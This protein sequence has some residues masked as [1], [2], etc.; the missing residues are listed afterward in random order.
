MGEEFARH[1]GLSQFVIDLS[2]PGVEIRPIRDL[3]GEAHFNEIVFENVELPDDA[4]VGVE[5]QGWAQVNAELAFERSGPDRYLSAFPL[6][7]VSIDQLPE[8]DR[9]SSRRIGESYAQLA[10]L[11]EMSLSILNQLEEGKTPLQEAAVTKLIGTELEQS[12]PDL[13]RELLDSPAI[14]QRGEIH[15]E[16]LAYLTQAVPSFSLRGGTNE[17][18]RGIIAKGLGLR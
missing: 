9:L 13:V 8:K 7:P 6:L 18:M 5:N 16:M 1:K 12:T 4:L 3:T 2:L 11:R 10:V 15:S 17:I 14:V